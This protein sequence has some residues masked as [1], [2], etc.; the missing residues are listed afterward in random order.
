[1]NRRKIFTSKDGMEEADPVVL[2]RCPGHFS[3]PWPRSQIV[4][5]MI[6]DTAMLSLPTFSFYFTC[7]DERIFHCTFSYAMAMGFV[8]STFIS[9]CFLHICALILWSGFRL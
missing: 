2:G 6:Y 7:Y 9:V 1:M 5:V 3:H 8:T 4:M